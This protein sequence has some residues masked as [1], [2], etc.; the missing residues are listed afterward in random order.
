MP[1]ALCLTCSAKSRPYDL[2]EPA[3]IDQ[4]HV[5]VAVEVRHDI[6]CA[7]FV[8]REAEAVSYLA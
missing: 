2:L 6:G 8:Y 7:A 5:P 4:V 3:E 1:H